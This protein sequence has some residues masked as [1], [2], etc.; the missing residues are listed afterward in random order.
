[1]MNPTLPILAFLVSSATVIGI[2]DDGATHADRRESV[3]FAAPVLRP[4]DKFADAEYWRLTM[5]TEPLAV[6]PTDDELA[7]LDRLLA[8]LN[9]AWDRSMQRLDRAMQSRIEY[10]IDDGLRALVDEAQVPVMD[11]HVLVRRLEYRGGRRYLLDVGRGQDEEL[12]AIGLEQRALEDLAAD[13]VHDVFGT[14]P[15]GAR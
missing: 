12:D 15:G 8:E 6:V 1:M 14:V 10:A 13:L 2:R 9:H 3:P 11:E 5:A 7:D 4:Q